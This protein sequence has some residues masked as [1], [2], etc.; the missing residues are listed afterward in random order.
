MIYPR[1]LAELGSALRGGG[2]VVGGAAGIMS[3]AMPTPPGRVGIDLREMALNH[4]DL[5]AGMVSA[6]TSLAELDRLDLSAWPAVAA[7]VRATATPAARRL[8]TVGGVLGA[9]QPRT[10]LAPALAVH[11]TR[12]RVLLS[13]Q[14]V[15]RWIPVLETWDLEEPFAVLAI[16]LGD[17]GA[18]AFRR[19]ASHQPIG[20]SLVSVA[21]RPRTSGGYKICVSA[22]TTRPRFVAVDALPSPAEL[23]DDHRAS[24]VYRH[25][26]LGVLVSDL[27]LDLSSMDAL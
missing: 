16:Q 21:A 27:L 20:P 18:S 7:A 5:T 8:I 17:P 9:R 12:V 3:T 19:F 2:H 4:T 11:G 10:D 23:V 14:R 22:A 6:L 26:L 24:A 25:H 13:G 1:T 15:C